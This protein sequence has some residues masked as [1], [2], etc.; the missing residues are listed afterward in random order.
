MVAPFLIVSRVYD[1]PKKLS[2]DTTT[3]MHK[4]GPTE[5]QRSG[6]RATFEI[7]FYHISFFAKSFAC[8]GA[9]RSAKITRENHLPFIPLKLGN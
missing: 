4:R 7:R 9:A 6:S 1:L 8:A 2:K 5:S 3:I